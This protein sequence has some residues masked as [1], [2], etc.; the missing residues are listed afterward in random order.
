MVPP[1][2]AEFSIRSRVRVPLGRHRPSTVSM[3]LGHLRQD[4]V[5]PAAEVAAEVEDDAVGLDRLGRG[6]SCRSRARTDFRGSL[7]SEAPRL[8]R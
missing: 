5:E 8:I 3:R 7:R 6:A 2:P 4:G 1:A